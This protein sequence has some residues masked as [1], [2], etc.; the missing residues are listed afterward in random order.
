[1][2][3]EHEQN[4]DYFRSRQPGR[5]LDSQADFGGNTPLS[6]AA[7]L[8]GSGLSGLMDSAG[9]GTSYNAPIRAQT[10]R[11]AQQ[12]HGNRAVQRYLG[13]SGSTRPVA[14][15]RGPMDYMMP[16]YAEEAKKRVMEEAGAQEEEASYNEEAGTARKGRTA[17]S[18]TAT[19]L[20][21]GSKALSATGRGVSAAEETLSL[22]RL[23]GIPGRIE[24]AED[25]LKGA[26]GAQESS[27]INRNL[28]SDTKV[29]KGLRG[30]NYVLQFVENLT[31]GQDLDEALVGAGA[32]GFVN[33]NITRMLFDRNSFLNTT[34]VT[35]RGGFGPVSRNIGW[36]DTAVNLT[37]AGVQLIAPHLGMSE[38]TTKAVTTATQTVADATPSSFATSLG[39][40]AA[41]GLWNTVTGDWDALE[42]Q[43]QSIVQGKEGAPLQGYGMAV[44]LFTGDHDKMLEES[45]SG[46]RGYL[47]Q[48]GTRIGKWARGGEYDEWD[49]EREGGPAARERFL[50]MQ[51][52]RPMREAIVAAEHAQQKKKDQAEKERFDKEMAAI[53]AQIAKGPAIPGNL[54]G[55]AGDPLSAQ[56]QL[57]RI[58]EAQQE[59]EDEEPVPYVPMALPR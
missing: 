49:A 59:D 19:A 43:G 15:Q 44:E 9:I 8:P 58:R 12:T 56:A 36:V 1:M 3:S 57:A 16:Q 33:N 11:E 28:G 10:I 35:N 42:K 47:A 29:G 54:L 37:N 2:A 31:K 23:M 17:A 13:A 25:V 22:E 18:K 24:A 39:S 51:A 46:K 53:S 55:T 34:K 7:M 5:T 6:Q 52:A 21:E 30:S 14:V 45:R 4:T 20:R 50:K 26:K 27:W 40:N 48:L 38:D 32:G 41:R